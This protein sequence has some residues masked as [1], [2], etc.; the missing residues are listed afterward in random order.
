[1][2]VT[3][4]IIQVNESNVQ[5]LKLL[6]KDAG[7]ETEQDIAVWIISVSGYWRSLGYDKIIEELHKPPR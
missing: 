6:A 7:K 5:A 2:A 4:K 3:K 1:M